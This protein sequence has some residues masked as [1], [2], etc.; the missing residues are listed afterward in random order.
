M[1]QLILVMFAVL[2][3]IATSFIAAALR[4]LSRWNK[5]YDRLS[6][7]YGGQKNSRLMY[8]FLFNRPSLTFDY[9]RTLCTLK[10]RKT[11]RFSA[12]R[13][14]EIDMLWPDRKFR[15]EVGTAPTRSRGWGAMAMKQIEIDDS[16]FQSSFYV[17]SNKTVLAE[18]YLNP[19][20]QWQLEQLRRHMNNNELSLNISRGRLSIAKPGYIKG[21][22]QLEDFVRFSLEL[23]DQLMLVNAEGI[24]FVNADQA[25][26]VC[27]VK[28][29]ICSEEIMQE[30]VVCS[31]CKTPHCQD[32]WQYNGQCATF[33]CNETRF[34]NAAS[35]SS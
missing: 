10:N 16:Q 12:K 4:R 29:P 2:T 33:A 21:Y 24:E 8:G 14:T 34:L 22:Q 25:S 11:S 35:V 6:K 3:V 26:V 28:C 23:F 15:L 20:I 7:R 1:G 27:D 17:S 30:M 32:C 18:R 9:G 13:Q 31:R 5:T 19:G